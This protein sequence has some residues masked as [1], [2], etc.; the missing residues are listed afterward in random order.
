M[1]QTRLY[2]PSAVGFSRKAFFFFGGGV[3]RERG[4]SLHLIPIV[5]RQQNEAACKATVG[6]QAESSGGGGGGGGGETS[7]YRFR[8]K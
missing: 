2:V 7:P 8:L 1:C 3:V 6:S 4:P 5:S